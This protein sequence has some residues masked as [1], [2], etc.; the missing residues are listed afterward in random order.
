MVTTADTDAVVLLALVGMAAIAKPG[1]KDETW[2]LHKRGE[3]EAS[4]VQ[5]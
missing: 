1:K 4:E 3:R 5:G 2:V